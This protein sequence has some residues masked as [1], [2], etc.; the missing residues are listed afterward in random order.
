MSVVSAR[1][2]FVRYALIGVGSNLILY[3]GYIGL[4]LMGVDPKLAMTLLY[5]VGVAQTFAFNK[6]WS[7]GHD[8]AMGPAFVRY[9]ISY[10]L[11]YLFNL[12]A[13]FVL[14]DRLGYPHRIVQAVLV[15]CTAVLLFALQKL[16][17]FRSPAS[18]TT[19][20]RAS[21]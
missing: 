14:V 10:G 16:W 13:L 9:C 7:F 19:A 3:L 15:L 11:G 20:T 1:T 8:G 18:L 21:L 2:Q 17:V 4:T 12:A 5:C 6:R